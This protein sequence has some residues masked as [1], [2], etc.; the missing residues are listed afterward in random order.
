ML[1]DSKCEITKDY[2]LI[3]IAKIQIRTDQ[4]EAAETNLKKLLNEYPQSYYLNE[5]RSLLEGL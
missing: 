3:K 5:A 1:S 2:I 4:S